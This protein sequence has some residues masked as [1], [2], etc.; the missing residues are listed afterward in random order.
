M[1]KVFFSFDWD[2]VWR[3]NQVRNSWV[4]KGNYQ[5]AGFVDSA[6]IE[7]FK[8]ATDQPIRNWID[9]QLNGTSVTCVLI[10]S[11][12]CNSKW[13]KYEIQESINKQNGLLG[14]YIHNLKDQRGNTT[15]QGGKPFKEISVCPSYFDIIDYPGGSYYDWENDNG[16]Q[17]LGD[18]IETSAQQAGR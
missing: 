1:R 18:W 7:S 4:A 9:D 8:K 17:K 3:V 11:E 14:I 16:Y 5:N 6:D 13:V 2:D 15:C 12:T 10:G